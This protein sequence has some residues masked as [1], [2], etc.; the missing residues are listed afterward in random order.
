M[1]SIDNISSLTEQLIRMS[2]YNP[3]FQFVLMNKGKILVV[4]IVAMLF[5]LLLTGEMMKNIIR[6]RFAI[7]LSRFAVK[8]R[9]LGR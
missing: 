1:N 6:K 2:D 3:Y 7:I 8:H 4:S 5:L 9:P